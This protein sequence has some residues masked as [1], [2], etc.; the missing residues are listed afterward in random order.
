MILTKQV[1]ETSQPFPER[2]KAAAVIRAV[3][4]VHKTSTSFVKSQYY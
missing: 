4:P 3:E 1:I 2:M